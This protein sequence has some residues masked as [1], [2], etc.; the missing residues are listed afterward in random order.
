MFN[1]YFF[2]IPNTLFFCLF[3]ALDYV[4]RALWRKKEDPSERVVTTDTA[5]YYKRRI[6]I[7]NRMS[8]SL[9][10]L[11]LVGGVV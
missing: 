1:N 6:I 2:F 5:T 11:L 8:Y 10:E 4:D 7:I 9:S 3:L